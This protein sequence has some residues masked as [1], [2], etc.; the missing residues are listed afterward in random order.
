MET[1]PPTQHHYPPHSRYI[2]SLSPS[3]RSRPPSLDPSVSLISTFSACPKADPDPSG[4]SNEHRNN[5]SL[6]KLSR[7]NPRSIP[8]HELELHTQTIPR[9]SP[10]PFP[11]TGWSYTH[12]NSPT[13]CRRPPHGV[14]YRL[15]S[16][17]TELKI[18]WRSIRRRI[19]KDTQEKS[20]FQDGCCAT[21]TNKA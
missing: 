1:S 7:A 17:R 16:N 21:A 5:S 6:Y 18:Y 9:P 13:S 14:L 15:E 12:I 2:S 11:H 10:A 4:S 19:P 20:A 8:I 3:S